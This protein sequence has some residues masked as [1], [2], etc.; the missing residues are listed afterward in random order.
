MENLLA[1]TFTGEVIPINIKRDEILGR[2]CYKTI[3]EVPIT[4]DLAV[5][6][7][8]APIIPTIAKECG[9]AGVK[10]LLIISAGFTEAG[11]EGIKRSQQ[12]LDLA[13]VYGMQILGPNCLG[14]IHPKL[15]I[16]ASFASQ[17][18]L[19]GKLAF[20][21]QSGALCTSILDW[22]V[23]QSIG[24]SY[25]V[26]TGAML[27]TTFAD[28]IEYFSEDED[29]DCILI[30]MESLRAAED[31]MSIARKVA[32]KKPIL[33]LKAGRSTA[34]QSAA[35]S[36]TGAL[37]GN[38][39]IFDLA[40]KRTGVLRLD[41]IEQLFDCAQALAM[42]PYPAGH[43]LGIITNAGGPGVLATD[44]LVS[45]GGQL[46][47][48]SNTCIEK[49]NVFLPQNWSKGNPVDL[50]GD[51]NGEAYTKAFEV[52]KQED[53]VDGILLILTP[54]AM[55]NP[56]EVAE[57]IT[58][59][60]E[61]F[62]KPVL[63]VWMGEAAVMDG[64]EVLEQARIPN[65]RYPENAVLAF[66]QMFRYREQQGKLKIHG[67]KRASNFVVDKIAAQKIIA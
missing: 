10:G 6:C 19:P 26:S 14:F 67:E 38:D 23:D 41:T 42:Q 40:F 21:S 56:T 62:N 5:L 17:M 33:I 35:H 20:I 3:G 51:A 34:G 12:I 46:A 66:L 22:S 9:E 13:Q 15:G 32:I 49:L 57:K 44:Y 58:A 4:I 55:T 50:L 18:A 31:F 11:T 53:G 64:R 47:N 59:V 29:T 39:K 37:A 8:R 7:I 30:Y 60:A 25:F 28:L 27:D 36:H 52:L 54:Q 61:G 2:S 48:L 16:N 45:N 63:A 43:R 65:F 24:F 1:G